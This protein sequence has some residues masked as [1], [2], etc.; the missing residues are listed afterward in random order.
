MRVRGNGVLPKKGTREHKEHSLQSQVCSREL[1]EKKRE[2][3]GA[4]RTALLKNSAKTN[5]RHYRELYADKPDPIIFLPV[6]D[7][8]SGP[9]VASMMTLSV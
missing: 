2:R 9:R 4:P 6:A 3:E 5:I 8:T 1:G 7:S